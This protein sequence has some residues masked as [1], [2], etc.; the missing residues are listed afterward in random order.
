MSKTQPP[1]LNVIK[2]VGQCSNWRHDGRRV[3]GLIIS[4]QMAHGRKRFFIRY[5]ELGHPQRLWD[6]LLDSG[7]KLPVAPRARK[8]LLDAL[9]RIR[10]KRQYRAVDRPGWHGDQYVLPNGKVVG[11]RQALHK[12]HATFMRKTG[13]GVEDSN[14]EYLFGS[15]FALA[16]GA[17]MLARRFGLVSW[18][19]KIVLRAI[20]ETY[21]AARADVQ[22]EPERVA[23]ALMRLKRNLR[24][25]KRLV[26]IRPGAAT[27]G[28]RQRHRRAARYGYRSTARQ[29][30]APDLSSTHRGGG[31]SPDRGHLHRLAYWRTRHGGPSHRQARPRGRSTD[32]QEQDT[33]WQSLPARPDRRDGRRLHGARRVP[34]QQRQNA[35]REY[36]TYLGLFVEKFGETYW[37]RLAPGAARTWLKARADKSGPSGAHAL[38]R[39]VRAFFGQVRLCYDDLDHPGFVPEARNPFASLNLSLPKAPMILR[40]R[41]AVEAFVSLADEWDQP[42]IGDA[43]VMM[44]WLGVRR[45]DWIKWPAS[46]FDQDLLA[47]TQD[48]TDKALVIPWTLVPPLVARVAGAKARRP[49][50]AVSAAT[51]FHDQQ[52]RPWRNHAA[53]RT[54]FTALRDELTKRQ[55]HFPRRYYVGI[56]PGDPLSLPTEKLTMRTMRHTCVTL[57]HD[58]GCRAS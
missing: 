51:F 7:C 12:Y 23:D 49:A 44:S 55:P 19:K 21:R 14:W 36:K 22:S 40:P 54:A 34:L 9:Q 38:Y 35:E 17:A 33:D 10:P 32:W 43:I 8:R 15:G 57:N 13:I 5:S 24:S 47:F 50:D 28:K 48:K 4:V 41:A 58:A 29:V 25:K 52:G 30:R 2:A 20:Q 31:V 3:H 39:T 42:S 11:N 45:Q 37:Y 18:S 53:F 26:D 6:I 46:V 56:A 16:F 1:A 27:L